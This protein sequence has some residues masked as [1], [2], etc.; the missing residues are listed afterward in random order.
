MKPLFPHMY[1]KYLRNSNILSHTACPSQA[2]LCH[3]LLLL[4]YFLTGSCVLPTSSIVFL[5]SPPTILIF[6][7]LATVKWILN[8]ASACLL[9]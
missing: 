3:V 6:L 2:T 4:C 5:S 9:F 7:K 1:R 8:I